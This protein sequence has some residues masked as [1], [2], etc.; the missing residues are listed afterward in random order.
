MRFNEARDSNN[1]SITRWRFTDLLLAVTANLV[2][3]VVFTSQTPKNRKCVRTSDLACRGGLMWA[4]AGVGGAGAWCG[5]EVHGTLVHP[6]SQL[7]VKKTLSSYGC[8]V[9]KIV[10]KN[11]MGLITPK[12]MVMIILRWTSF[13]YTGKERWVPPLHPRRLEPRPL[14]SVN[15]STL[16]GLCCALHGGSLRPLT[17]SPTDHSRLGDDI[18]ISSDL[19]LKEL[20]IHMQLCVAIKFNL[21]NQTVTVV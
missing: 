18:L 5:G 3:L 14:A 15:V 8:G 7:C 12:W 1:S 9:E 10:R 11:Y 17:L 4:C 21:I 19:S 2:N 20:I 13:R 16:D 6:E